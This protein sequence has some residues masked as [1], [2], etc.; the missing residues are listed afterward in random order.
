MSGWRSKETRACEVCAKDYH[1]SR[2]KD[3]RFCGYTCANKWKATRGVMAPENAIA[4]RK[5]VHNDWVRATLRVQFGTIT[6]R[7]LAIFLFGNRH[8]YNRGHAKGYYAGRRQMV[9]A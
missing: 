9:A 5:R 4:A 7:E 3:Q 6:E 2:P 1:P 8:G